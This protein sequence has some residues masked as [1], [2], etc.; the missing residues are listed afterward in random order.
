MIL[1]APA[2]ETAPQACTPSEAWRPSLGGA[3]HNFV[4]VRIF[5]GVLLLLAAG[6]K[7]H[8][9]WVDPAPIVG[10]FASPRWQ[11]AFIEAELVLG[12]WLLSG[13]YPR[14]AWL[15]AC[16]AF[17]LFAGT[18][19]YLG[20]AGQASCG[21]FGRLA[22]STWTALALDL[23]ALFALW[24]SRP[25]EVNLRLL[26]VASFRPS[27][28]RLCAVAAVVTVAGI[29]LVSLPY[30]DSP[31]GAALARLRGESIG[32]DPPLSELG[33]GSPGEE[34]QF[35]ITLRN[36]TDRPMRIIGGT[37]DCSCVTTSDLPITVPQGEARRITVM[38]RFVGPV[39][40]A[41]QVFRLFTDDEKHPVVMARFTRRLLPQ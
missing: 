3:L 6:F 33:E 4:V 38:A 31:L 20:L 13:A 21:C 28:L 11:V 27:A 26:S 1:I 19:L 35:E 41:Q 9:L 12:I 2:S 40:V 5:L 34:R 23:G 22:V 16:V 18:S 7:A 10:L 37:A 25:A 14:R 32:V 15:A 29:F 17:L 8:A 36:Y 30:S 39:G 24:I